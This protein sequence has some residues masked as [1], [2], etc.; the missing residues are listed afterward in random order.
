MASTPTLKDFSQN[1]AGPMHAA[2]EVVA[3]TA[4]FSRLAEGL[5]RM[6]LA[7]DGRFENRR[8][9]RALARPEPL[10]FD[11][12][13]QRAGGWELA[14]DGHVLTYQPNGDSF[15]AGNLQV[16]TAWG[17]VWHPELVDLENLG[18]VHASLDLLRPGALPQG[19]HPA[20]FHHHANTS[21]LT[22]YRVAEE[23]KRGAGKAFQGRLM[24]ELDTVDHPI[25]EPA[26]RLLQERS[27]FPPGPLSRAGWFLYNDTG[28]PVLNPATGW[29]ESRAARED[30]VDAYLFLYGQDRRLGL[31]QHRALF[32]ACPLLPRYALGLWYSRFPTFNDAESRELIAEFE[33]HG[34]PLD[35]LVLDLEW[36]RLGWHGWSWNPEYFPDP[37]GF[38]DHLRQ[39]G[40]HVTLNVHPDRIPTEEP[41]YPAFLEAAGLKGSGAGVDGGMDPGVEKFGGYDLADPRQAAAFMD[42]LHR[43]VQ[44]QGVDFW[45]I[46]GAAPVRSIGG[47]D[48]QFWT[49]H[50]YWQHMRETQPRRRPMVFSRTAGF[51]AHRYPF[52]FTGDTWS[53]WAV[54]ENLVEQTLRAGHMG[55]SFVTHDIGGHL[56]PFVMLDPELYIRWVQFAVLNPIIRLHS[57]KMGPK[58][59]GERRPWM[60]GP[61]VLHIFQ[62]AMRL[63]REL[64]PYLYT[65]VR[66]TESE[67]LPI[68]RSNALERPDWEA[69]AGIWD[70]YFLGD[71]IYAAPM[72]RPGRVRSVVL[73]PGS[74]YRAESEKPVASNG[75]QLRRELVTHENVPLHYYRAGS[76]MVKAEGGQRAG[77]IP[78]SLRVELF[79]GGP[80]SKDEFELYEDDGTSPD[81]LQGAFR[82]RKFRMEEEGALVLE[83]GPEEGE[84]PGAP[85]RRDLRFQLIGVRPQRVLLDGRPLTCPPDAAVLPD[86]P[87]SQGARLVW[88]WSSP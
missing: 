66:Q 54:L 40:I 68:V 24:D 13:V 61:Q 56:S 58:T 5:V 19:V 34:L 38:L 60:Y 52:H 75:E 67:G 78:R 11:A 27:K 44:E 29:V 65:L 4:R 64:V 84:F 59:A 49:N 72:V 79:S 74:W 23:L 12:V 70:S 62:T 16:R 57:G 3:G 71:R 46:D 21:D 76:L 36:H 81:Y 48:A 31:R 35:M 50:V 87:S 18:G 14:F 53:S 41:G 85:Q 26:A 43:P 1:P 6:E 42:V 7:R 39:K 22:F 51:G 73:P 25:P 47:L 15:N 83:F 8:S 10:P 33:K 28:S 2:N 69:G 9:L 45:W 82:T 80:G 20:A 30:G 77:D 17:A 32:G 55:Q 37:A 86:W 88:T 63:R